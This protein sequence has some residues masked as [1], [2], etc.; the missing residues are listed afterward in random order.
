M[1]SRVSILLLATLTLFFVSCRG[2]GGAK[3]VEFAE[4][5]FKSTSKA[6]PKVVPKAS[7]AGLNVG[8]AAKYSDDAV[9]IYNQYNK[10]SQANQDNDYNY[11][12]NSDNYDYDYN[13]DD[14]YPEYEEN[15]IDD[16]YDDDFY[17]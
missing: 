10:N 5:A 6:A 9:R 16:D 13:V 11:N 12:S 14:E 15:Y 17:Y 7:K 3:A 8:A 2:K 4:Q 1:K